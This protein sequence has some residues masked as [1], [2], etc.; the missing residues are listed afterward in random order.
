MHTHIM[1]RAMP[2]FAA[3][4]G[5]G[6][7]IQ[8]DHHRPGSARMMLDG[9][10]FREVESNCW[11]AAERIDEYEQLGT[12]VQVVCTIPVLFAY[13]AE[14]RDGLQVARFLNNDLATTVSAHPRRYIG[15]GTLPMQAPDLAIDELERCKQLGLRGVQIGSN[16]NGN[17][18]DQANYFAVFEAAQDLDMAV[19]VHPWNM[20]GK[21]E[22]ERYWLPWLVGMPAESSRAACSLIFGGVLERLPRLRVC[23][24]H[25]GGSFLPTLGR[26]R[27]GHACRPDLVAIDNPRD[28]AEYLGKFWIDSITHDPKLL[29]YVLDLVGDER[30]MLGSDYPFPLGDLTIGAFIEEMGLAPKQVERIFRTNAL[31][32][33]GVSDED[34]D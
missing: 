2:D 19:F 27:H 17:N 5:Y 21:P 32:W 22:M 4:F 12:T 8:L 29:R 14:P 24:A 16:V 6:G 3:E 18:L 1:P 9:R 25:A 23:F 20:M 11:D 10:F 30:V 7:F 33:L 31:E 26:I 15:L 13:F 34:Y 28:P